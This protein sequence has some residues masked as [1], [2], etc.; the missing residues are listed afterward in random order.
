MVLA[1]GDGGLGGVGMSSKV[2]GPGSDFAGG[3][4]PTTPLGWWAVASTGFVVLLML[5][6]PLITVNYREVYPITDSWVMPA[7]LTLSVDAAAVLH[8]VAIWQK[9]ERSNLSVVLAVITVSAALFFTFIAIGGAV[10]PAH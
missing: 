2:K 6:F 10:V 1:F 4:L 7:V 8:V 3:H 9:G 5:A